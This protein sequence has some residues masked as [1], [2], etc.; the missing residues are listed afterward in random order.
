ML[1]HRVWIC[2]PLRT[3]R[4]KKCRRNDLWSYA[5]FCLEKLSNRIGVL[6]ALFSSFHLKHV[7]TSISTLNSQRRVDDDVPAK[8]VFSTKNNVAN[9]NVNSTIEIH[10]VMRHVCVAQKV[11]GVRIL[12]C[13]IELWMNDSLCVFRTRLYCHCHCLRTLNLEF[14]LLIMNLLWIFSLPLTCALYDSYESTD[15]LPW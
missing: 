4:K 14:F 2:F 8:R 5:M 15:S 11:C 3:E 1:T 7:N 12:Y 10:S 13:D 6:F 9:I